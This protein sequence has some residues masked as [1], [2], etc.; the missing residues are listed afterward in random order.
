MIIILLSLI[1]FTIILLDG[2]YLGM[3]GPT[4]LT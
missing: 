2:S 1:K 3:I 4:G